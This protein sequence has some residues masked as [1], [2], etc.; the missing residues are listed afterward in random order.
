VKKII[1]LH[2]GTINV[3]SIEGE[4]STFVIKL[5]VNI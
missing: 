1:D 3:D 2:F 4:G 5:P